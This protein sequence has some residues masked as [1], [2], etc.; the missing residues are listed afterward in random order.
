MGGDVHE[1]DM[2]NHYIGMG[3]L[4]EAAQ[5]ER[6]YAAWGVGLVALL[7]LAHHPA[8]GPQDRAR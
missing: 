2:L 8:R 6:H 7:V 4:A 5:F 1:I 3:H